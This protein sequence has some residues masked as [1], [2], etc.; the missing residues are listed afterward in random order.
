MAIAG[1]LFPIS[2][3]HAGAAPGLVATAH[4]QRTLAAGSG[5]LGLW[6]TSWWLALRATRSGAA[7][8]RIEY[9]AQFADEQDPQTRAGHWDVGV[10]DRDGFVGRIPVTC[11]TQSDYDRRL[12]VKVRIVDTN[13]TASDWVDVSFPAAESSGND[14]ATPSPEPNTEGRRE[15]LG[16]VQIVANEDMTIAAAKA[17]LLRSAREK[18]GDATT[19]FRVLE[20]SADSVTFAA[21][22]VRYV[23][24]PTIPTPARSNTA[25]DRVLAELTM[26]LTR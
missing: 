9:R 15:S 19:G 4:Q 26:P 20:S 8:A 11:A 16:T 13:N 17:A 22:V 3:A 10:D 12:R 25:P 24:A 6:E 2:L 1:L 21:D 5:F 18:G 7:L 23:D 14:S